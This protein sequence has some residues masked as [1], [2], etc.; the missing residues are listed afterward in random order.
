MKKIA[1]TGPHC[2]GKSTVINQIKED[3]K[4]D[5][6]IVFHNFSGKSSPIDYSS[7]SKLKNDHI[8]E[9]DI[10]YYLIAKLLERE[11]EIEYEENEIVVLDRCLIDQ[12]VYPSVLLPEKYHQN[13]F[14]FLKL[15]F[16][17]HPYE[18]LFYIPKNYDLLTKY[19]TKDKSKEYLD[20]IEETYLTI[21]KKLGIK[22]LILPKE[23]EKQIEQ[24]EEYLK[25][26]KN[27]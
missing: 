27:K 20:K 17:I 4:D 19:G 26:V 9:I 8:S 1:V 18:I 22:Y 12:I 23:Q 7:S 15:W 24:I 6:K 10:T 14:D 16:K 3:F 25:S 21:L 2:S 13:I 11:V 5:T